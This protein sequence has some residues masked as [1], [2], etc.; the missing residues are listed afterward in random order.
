MFS[1]QFDP[2]SELPDDLTSEVPE[3][4]RKFVKG[5]IDFG[6]ETKTQRREE[7][8]ISPLHL[9]SVQDYEK[10]WREALEQMVRGQDR[11]ALIV[12]LGSLMP[13]D[14]V[15]WWPMWRFG[16]T[17]K[18]QEHLLFLSELSQPFDHTNPY[19]HVREYD[20]EADEDGR[21]ASEWEVSVS[22]MAAFLE[23]QAKTA[24]E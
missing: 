12:S 18:L 6:V 17:I 20:N 9:W 8:F 7:W 19:V 1:I 16:K 15:N 21:R 3:A 13:D 24:R 14:Y 10:H 4:Y 2:T 22:D 11:S 23:A 5:Y